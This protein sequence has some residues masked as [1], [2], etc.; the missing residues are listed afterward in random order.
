MGNVVTIS[1]A[2]D[3]ES[4]DWLNSRNDNRSASLRKII[5]RYKSLVE[6][7]LQ[8]LPFSEREWSLLE[9]ILQDGIEETWSIE[10]L[11]ARIA[12]EIRKK[13]LDKKWHVEPKELL[14]KISSLTFPEKIA[15]VD[16]CETA[17]PAKK[18]YMYVK[19]LKK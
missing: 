11:E 4:I 18:G 6:Y 1:F 19:Y 15:I 2:L 12:R 10:H 5:E 16:R 13:G 8:N 14:E 17:K 3:K 7:Y 9:E